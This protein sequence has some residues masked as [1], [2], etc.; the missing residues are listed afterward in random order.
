M[1]AGK[2]AA[3]T[4]AEAIARR[5]MIAKLL[6][7]L[8]QPCSTSDLVAALKSQAGL[9]TNPSSLLKDL[10]VLRRLKKVTYTRERHKYL[11]STT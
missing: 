8:P 11:W 9:E 6:A 3:E 2:P 10:D 1:T 5:E 4:Y 7:T